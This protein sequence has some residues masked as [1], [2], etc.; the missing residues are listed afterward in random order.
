[1]DGSRCCDGHSDDVERDVHLDE[2][3]R[4]L[5][6]SQPP[7]L[8]QGGTRRTWA[9]PSRTRNLPDYRGRRA[10]ARVGVGPHTGLA[11]GGPGTRA[12]VWELETCGPLQPSS[13]HRENES[14]RNQIALTVSHSR[15]LCAACRL[16]GPS[17]G[18]L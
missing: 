15:Q 16:C 1:M 5:P 17:S 10:R 14:I 13:M 8:T 2:G 12:D 18:C 7:G 4:F 3:L 11:T 6:S 9:P